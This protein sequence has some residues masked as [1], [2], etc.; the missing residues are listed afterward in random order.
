MKFD[1]VV[2][3]PAARARGRRGRVPQKA[4][5]DLLDATLA[6]YLKPSG[7]LVAVLPGPFGTPRHRMLRAMTGV[8]PLILDVDTDPHGPVPVHHGIL[9][10]RNAG[11]PAL[12]PTTVVTAVATFSTILDASI[13][14]LPSDLC[15]EALSIHRKVA[16]VSRTKMN[17][18][19]DTTWKVPARG[20]RPDG[21][22]PLSAE[23]STLHPHP[24]HHTAAMTLWAASRQDWADTP[25]VLWT[26]TGP[27][28]P[29]LD[30]GGP[31]GLGGT[32]N[33][34]YVPVASVKAGRILLHNMQTA[35]F[36]YLIDTARWPGYRGLDVL[37]ALPALPSHKRL[38]DEQ[39]Y[40]LFHL[41]PKE[42]AHVEQH[43]G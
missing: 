4:S 34:T 32:D 1:V 3:D 27:Y 37:R 14:W 7:L 33:V 5:A 21:T 31:D 26:R 41:T 25:K 40:D 6:S 36:R 16:F 20:T 30:E 23:H 10:A 38:T 17:P 29:L 22:G 9:L 35:L 28:R 13:L 11:N 43:L 12:A 24:V 42:R 8:T 2:T 15:A 18:S 19:R 39:M